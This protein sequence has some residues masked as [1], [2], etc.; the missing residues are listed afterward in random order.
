MT[1]WNLVFQN[2]RSTREADLAAPFPEHTTPAWIGD[3]VAR[4]HYLNVTEQHFQ[5]GAT[6]AIASVASSVDQTRGFRTD[7]TG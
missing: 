3:S 4:K 6:R 5:Q 2:C 1:P 7:D